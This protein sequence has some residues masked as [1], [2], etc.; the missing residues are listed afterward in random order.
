MGCPDTL[1]LVLDQ[2]LHLEHRPGC[3]IGAETDDDGLFRC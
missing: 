2:P 3:Q 1:T